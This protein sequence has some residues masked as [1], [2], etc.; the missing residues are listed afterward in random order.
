MPN[1]TRANGCRD[2]RRAAV[3]QQSQPATEPADPK[4]T[5]VWSPGAACGSR[6]GIGSARRPRTPVVLF[7]GRNSPTGS[8]K[9]E[10]R[11]SGRFRMVR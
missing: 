8:M 3:D 4:L 5:E 1:S 2:C 9:T 7:D 11:P 6:Q 10:A